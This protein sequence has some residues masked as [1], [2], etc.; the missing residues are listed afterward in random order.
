MLGPKRNNIIHYLKSF[1][2]EVINTDK[3]ID[4]RSE[5]LED[6]D[7]II[8]YGY[9]YLLSKNVINRFNRKAV[10]LHISL[11]PW[12]RGADPNLWSFLED[13]PKGVTIHYMDSGLD[14]GDI[15]AQ[16]E[17]GYTQ[18]DTL[19]TSY[20]RLIKEIENLFFEVWPYIR[21]GRVKAFPQPKEG[22]YHRLIDKKPYEYLL[23]EG[24]DTP[25]TKLIGKALK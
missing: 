20:D 13:T 12:N 22:T 11:L 24:W 25:V 4:E 5:Y 9:R 17:V 15:I 7:F 8:S 3:K 14:T 2:D 21:S 6:V 23:T 19:R 16:R 10:N 1:G 18:Q